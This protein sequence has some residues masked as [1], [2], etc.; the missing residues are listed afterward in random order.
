MRLRPAIDRPVASRVWLDAELGDLR[1]SPAD[2]EAWRRFIARSCDRSLEQWRLHPRAARS[3]LMAHLALLA[4]SR[5]PWVLISFAYCA[6]H[7]GL[8]G[9][10]DRLSSADLVSLLRANLPALAPGSRWTVPAAVLSDGLDG[11]L[12]R[13]TQRTTAFGAYLDGLADAAFWTWFATVREPSM[14]VRILGLAFWAL[15]AAG[16]TAA[17]FIT[18]R[19]IDYPRLKIVRRASA[20]IQVALAVRAVTGVTA[21]RVAREGSWTRSTRRKPSRSFD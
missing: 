9:D 11:W 2:P 5:R 19:S 14:A 12:A 7:L 16:I 4:A 13:R 18:G 15:P 21:R 6:G 3:V 20:V 8:L 17:Y 10:D 1:R